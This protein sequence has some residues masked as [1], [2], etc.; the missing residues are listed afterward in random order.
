MKVDATD[1]QRTAWVW[2]TLSW[3]VVSKVKARLSGSSAPAPRHIRDIELTNMS[4]QF[5]SWWLEARGDRPMPVRDDVSPKALVE[6]LPYFRLLRWES[7]NSLVFR[8]FGSALAEATGF[9]LTGYCTFGEADYEGKAEDIARLKLMHS[10]PCGLLLH[11][12][13]TGPDGKNY[14]CELI[15]L[16]VLGGG[17]GKDTIVG[18]VVTRNEVGEMMLDFKLTPPLH[19]VRAVFIDIGF[20]VPENVPYL[21]L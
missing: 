18:T 10:H 6:L 15:N 3:D 20:G 11:R 2:P 9:D 21:E 14:I 7:E 1:N 19:L 16:P 5:F 17:D 12:A 4:H 8:I 13:L